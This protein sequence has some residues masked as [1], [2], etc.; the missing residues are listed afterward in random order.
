MFRIDQ[1]INNKENAKPKLPIHRVGQK[2]RDRKEKH[3]AFKA[4][5]NRK[6][7]MKHLLLSNASVFNSE[8]ELESHIFR[9]VVK[10][11]DIIEKQI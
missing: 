4:Y 5:E 11:I 2:I 9:A 8:D 6:V 7:T 3:Q 1:R 10:L